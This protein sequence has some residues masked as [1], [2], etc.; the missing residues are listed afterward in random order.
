MKGCQPDA[1]AAF[2]SQ[3]IPSVF[4]SVKSQSRSQDHRAA[5][6]NKSIENVNNL[7]PK[8]TPDHP[9]FSTVRQPRVRH[10]PPPRPPHTHWI[11]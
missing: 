8:Q 10:P 7:R 5:R 9:H 3:Q 2:T 1:L 6:R 4:V 11:F